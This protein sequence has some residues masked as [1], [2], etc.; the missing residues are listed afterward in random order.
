MLAGIFRASNDHVVHQHAGD[1]HLPSRN[2]SFFYQ[3]VCLEDHNATAVMGGCRQFKLLNVDCLVL[4][5][6]VPRLVYTGDFDEADID[7]KGPVKKVFTAAQFQ[8]PDEFLVVLLALVVDPTSFHPRVTEGFQPHMGE[9]ARFPRRNGTH[10]VRDHPLGGHVSREFVRGDI[11]P[12]DRRHAVV[13]TVELTDHAVMRE[14]IQAACLPV[15]GDTGC[16][17]G[18]QVPGV[19]FRQ[20]FLLHL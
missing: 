16:E 4:N 15:A 11:L 17:K 19:P 6:G 9:N 18:E 10:Q 7:G 8:Q 2:R 20:E 14:M 3:P 5:G 12:H 13:P 1:H